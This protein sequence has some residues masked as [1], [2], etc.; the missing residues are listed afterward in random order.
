MSDKKPDEKSTVKVSTLLVIRD[1]DT[2]EVLVSQ[3][4]D[5]QQVKHLGTQN[6]RKI[7]Q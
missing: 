2:K 3:K 4:D 5:L 6:D 7:E 1:K